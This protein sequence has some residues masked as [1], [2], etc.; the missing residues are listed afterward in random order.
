MTLKLDDRLRTLVE[1]KPYARFSDEELARRRRAL[2]GAMQKMQV[3]HLLVCGEQRVGSGV[4]W[5]TGWPATTEA[6]VIVS[7]HE[8][9]L[10]FMEW[11]NHFPLA[12]R[13]AHE[14]DVRWGEHA[15]IDKVI[16]ELQRRGAKR[17]GFIGPLAYRKCRKLEGAF[18]ALVEMNREYVELRLRKS[19]EEL[20]WLRVGAAYS[21]AA[22]EA[23]RR[24]LR[25]GLTERDLWDITERAYVRHGGFSHIHYFGATSM[26]DPDC[27]VPRQFPENRTI[28][29]GDVVFCE[30]SGGFWDYPGQVLRTFTVGA[31]ATPLY[32]D[33]YATAEAAFDAI[34]AVL[35]AGT[36]T[37]QIIEVSG[38]IEK[39]GFTTCDDLLHGYG[40]GYFP[41]V[42]GS[43]SR[44]TPTVPD[45]KLEAGMT[46]VVQPNVITQDQRAGVQVGELL[47][48][49]EHGF[50]RLHK[51]PRALFGV[52]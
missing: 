22:I 49:T 2:I 39:A 44:P 45:M 46:V 10:M 1:Q 40:G 42:L 52:G 24:E 17:V 4:A 50:E 34:A 27:C 6:L 21:D 31:D 25:P 18:E 41:P 33:L 19:R 38:V 26:A 30:L 32:R 11:Y 48:I 15:G 13:L 36:T 7:P 51:A 20:D 47:H 23:L 14:T 37:H 43:R 8:K 35:R 12:K 16:V 3:D 29:S 9:N 5:L 28:R